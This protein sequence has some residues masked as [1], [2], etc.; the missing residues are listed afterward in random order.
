MQNS[1]VRLLRGIED[2]RSDSIL[3]REVLIQTALNLFKE[4]G[5]E[6]PLTAIAKEAGVSRM[7]FYRNFPDRNALVVAVFHYNLDRLAEYAQELKDDPQGFYKLLEVVM[8]QRV[9]YNMLIAYIND[10]DI[11]LTSIKLSDIFTGLIQNAQGANLLRKDFDAE[12]DLLLLMSMMGGVISHPTILG[13]LNIARALDLV[14]KG[15]KGD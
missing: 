4:K 13:G 15:L 7:T 5:A 3:N 2:S 8:L 1:K 6:V 11:L 10:Q 9:E 14:G 12:K